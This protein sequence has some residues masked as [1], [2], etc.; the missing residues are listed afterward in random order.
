VESSEPVVGA[1]TVPI[2][3]HSA[4]QVVQPVVVQ[5]VAPVAVAAVT[6]A[7]VVVPVAPVQPVSN[8]LRFKLSAK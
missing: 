1:P 3:H 7:P 5:P 2:A 4:A 6:P 8:K